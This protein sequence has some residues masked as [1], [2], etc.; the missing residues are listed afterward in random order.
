MLG[1]ALPIARYT[2]LEAMRNRLL[3]L[4]VAAL[5][6]AFA[7]AG[8]LQQVSI[9][10][11]ARVQASLIAAAMRLFA[12]FLVAAFVVTAVVREINDK[13]LE[14]LLAKPLP[15]TS[16]LIGKCLGFAGVAAVV[17]VAAGL[18]LWFFGAP[19]GVAAWTAS[20]FFELLIIVA[21][22]VFCV[23]TLNQVVTAL[24]TVLGFYVLARTMATVQ[25]LAAAA[26]A[27][28]WRDRLT[29]G[30]VD[31]LAALLPSLDRMTATAWVVDGTGFASLATTAVVPALV[32][33]ALLGGAAAFDLHRQNF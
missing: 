17:A 23:L 9:T 2:L 24:A 29:G 26:G 25:I 12:V 32:Y 27:S 6:A 30:V 16:W 15:R 20:L 21:A 10:E 13:V 22:S 19:A 14:V 11:A 31:A 5:A 18:P 4:L 28:T 8:F 3:W 33:V 1:F 7:A